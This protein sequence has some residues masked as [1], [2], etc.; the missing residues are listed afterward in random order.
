MSWHLP[1][2]S[3]LL[4]CLAATGASL[5]AAP[6]PDKPVKLV[7][8]YAPGGGTDLIA[9]LLAEKLRERLG[10][11]V[12]VENKAGAN[13]SIGAGAVAKA[14]P[15]GYTLLLAGMGPL[16]INPTLI[17]QMS[18]VPAKDF[19]AITMV[20]SFALALVA[21][22][23]APAGD[24]AAL[25]AH[26]RQNPGKVTAANAGEGSPQH[27]CISLLAKRAKVELTDVPYKGSAP[28]IADMIG[29]NVQVECENIGTVLPFVKGGK[30]RPLAV[31]SSQRALLLPEVPSFRE[32][33]I[34]GADF[35][36]WFML[37]A[38]ADTPAEIVQRLNKD[39][40]EVLRQPDFVARLR[41]TANEP[42]G[43]SVQ[44]AT[45]FLQKEN[46]EWPPLL[47]TI[48]GPR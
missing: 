42:M 10:Q 14:A 38:P 16:A 30:L 9:R 20:S 43:G 1:L 15:D 35:S 32:L 3:L 34:A 40:N 48:Y 36:S 27:L 22:P 31:S 12:I 24:F 41:E 29:G 33:G 21:G 46:R 23:S 17:P 47:K 28:A 6:Y 44:A 45:E 19:A 37:V 7:V 13:G 8:P 11:S 25:L 2:R 26:A 5:H 18:Y 39:V 4:V